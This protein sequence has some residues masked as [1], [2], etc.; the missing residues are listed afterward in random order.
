MKNGTLALTMALLLSLPWIAVGDVGILWQRWFQSGFGSI[1]YSVAETSDGGYLAVG[2]RATSLG[3][4]DCFLLKASSD[5]DSIWSKTLGG[6]GNDCARS[7]RRVNDSTFIIAGITTSYSD[8]D[9]MWLM[10]INDNGDVLW[11]RNY[12][13]GDHDGAYDV[14][15]TP[16]GGYLMVG[17]TNSGNAIAYDVIMAKTDSVGNLKGSLTYRSAGGYELAFG[18]DTT[19]DGGYVVA[20]ECDSAS[21][22]RYDSQGNLQWKW[23]SQYVSLYDVKSLDDGSSISV[24][25]GYN[26]YYD[27]NEKMFIY[28]TLSNGYNVMSRQIGPNGDFYETIGF[29]V[30]VTDDGE[31]IFAGFT[32]IDSYYGGSYRNGYILKTNSTSLATEWE[33]TCVNGYGDSE[34]YSIIQT[35]DGNYIAAGE[36]GGNAWLVKVGEAPTGV[37]TNNVALPNN[38]LTLTSYPNPFNATTEIKYYLPTNQNIKLDIYDLLGQK[39]ETLYDG[40]QTAGYHSI[41]WKAKNQP[42]GIYFC[43]L[44]SG[45]IS[46]IKKMTLL[47]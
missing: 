22:L 21:L 38:Y 47:K 12:N 23:H 43:R 34:L 33:L 9:D 32:G 17:Q 2:Y 18:V 4:T 27:W 45:S 42:S 41:N 25:M 7:I 40:T 36:V 37:D 30:D 5:G 44:S 26:Y 13:F 15:K 10:Q 8:T 14:C 35:S 11:S 46:V 39:V 6:I 29:G 16:D 19:A 20:A 24:G 31:F 1:F 28:L 3:S